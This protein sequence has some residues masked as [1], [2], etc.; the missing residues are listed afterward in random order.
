MS[1]SSWPASATSPASS[2]AGDRVGFEVISGHP[3]DEELAAVLSV[4][5]AMLNT[6]DT[7]RE[8]DDRPMASGW[9]SYWRVVKQPFVPSREAWRG[10]IR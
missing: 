3:D 2:D 6:S 10:S 4:L 7:G 8:N 9:K 1:L 5:S